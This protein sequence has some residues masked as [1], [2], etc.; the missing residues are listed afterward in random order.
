MAET[1][2]V[3]IRTTHMGMVG[4]L[5]HDAIIRA[6]CDVAKNASDPLG[7]GD[8]TLLSADPETPVQLLRQVWCEG[9]DLETLCSRGADPVAVAV[10]VGDSNPSK[11]SNLPQPPKEV[12]DRLAAVDSPKKRTAL[13]ETRHTSMRLP[14][15]HLALAGCHSPPQRTGGSARQQDYAGVVLALLD[16]GARIDSRDL[17]GYTVLHR[18]GNLFANSKLVGLI[19]ILVSRGADANARHRFG[20]PPLLEASS[21]KKNR[22]DIVLS[23][24]EADADP[25]QRGTFGDMVAPLTGSNPMSEVHEALRLAAQ[26]RALVGSSSLRGRQVQLHGLSKAELNGRTGVCGALDPFK[27]RFSVDLDPSPAAGGAASTE[28]ISVKF[29]R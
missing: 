4:G 27:G 3:R 14:A 29:N 22:L 18:S 19:P 15:L 11:D 26:R 24:L 17:C 1:Q 13:L 2:P 12:R 10:F 25:A 7:D 9:G 28:T 8:Q 5:D 6:T 20:E 21:P 16:A 23:L